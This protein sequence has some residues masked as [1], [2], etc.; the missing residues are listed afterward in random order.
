MRSY[1]FTLFILVALILSGCSEDNIDPQIKNK[2]ISS[3][4]L[5]L[6]INTPTVVKKKN[7]FIIKTSL[8]YNGSEEIELFSGDPI[9]RVYIYDEKGMD[10]RGLEYSDLGV[11]RKLKPGESI[12]IKEEIRIKDPGEYEIV[13]QT[14]ELEINGQLIDGIGYEKYIKE[15]K[16]N[17]PNVP[18]WYVE[19]Q[20]SKI[21]IDDLVLTVK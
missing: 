7:S 19:A 13:I 20:K 11:N 21:I 14:T 16:K 17:K 8:L 6:K 4:N 10:V 12:D 3:S 18:D 5:D 15:L 1:L 9:I 2:S